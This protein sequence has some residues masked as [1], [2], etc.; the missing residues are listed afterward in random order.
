M[1]KLPSPLS[2]MD[3]AFH[4][5]NRSTK[6]LRNAEYRNAI[7]ARTLARRLCKLN[8]HVRFLVLDEDGD[9]TFLHVADS[10]ITPWVIAVGHF[11]RDDFRTAWRECQHL[12]PR[13]PGGVFVDVG[14]N[15]GTTT[16]YAL[17]T[18]DFSRAVCMEPSPENTKALKLN[19]LANDLSSCV[20][21]LEAACS[22]TNG[23]ADLW[24]TSGNQGDHRLARASHAPTT[25]ESILQVETLS[26]DAAM[27]RANVSPEE[28]SMVWVDTQGHEPGVLAGAAEVIAGGAPFCIEY[29]PSQYSEARSLDVLLG[30]VETSFVSFLDLGAAD[31]GVRPVSDILRLTDDLVATPT[32]QTDIILVPR[33]RK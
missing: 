27:D 28:I 16:L 26:L 7:A 4:I 1:T 29:W 8:P 20:H 9:L 19:V 24:V 33:N 23:K 6:L 10:V 3:R 15:V 17:R 12:V 2:A 14:A 32:G 30:I 5:V 22:D 25:H 11:Q 18:G 31:Q 21:I 13:R